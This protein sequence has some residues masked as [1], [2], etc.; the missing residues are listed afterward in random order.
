[1]PELGGR[2]TPVGDPTAPTGHRAQ[3]PDRE[4]D[5]ASWVLLSQRRRRVFL[6]AVAAGL[7]WLLVGSVEVAGVPE[8]VEGGCCVAEDV[9][10]GG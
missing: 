9:A 4:R 6:V 3:L 2:Q 5:A 10:D 7:C 8:P 1:M